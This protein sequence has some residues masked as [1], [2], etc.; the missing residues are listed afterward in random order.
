[1]VTAVIITL[2]TINIGL[3]VMVCKFYDRCKLLESVSE[4]LHN[5][6]IDAINIGRAVI[7]PGV[8]HNKL[9]MYKEEAHS[10]SRILKNKWWEG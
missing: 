7:E 9:L 4:T 6:L 3:L 1:M 10:A 8:I 5:R 2:L